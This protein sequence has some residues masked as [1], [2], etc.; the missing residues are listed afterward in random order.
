MSRNVRIPTFHRIPDRYVAI[1]TRLRVGES[2]G[3]LPQ[4]FPDLSGVRAMEI[5]RTITLFVGRCL[6]IAIRLHN[7]THAAGAHNHRGEAR[8]T[9]VTVADSPHSSVQVSAF[10]LR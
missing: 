6:M 10:P 9:S 5:T 2:V 7:R 1:H 4:G 3:S 8:S